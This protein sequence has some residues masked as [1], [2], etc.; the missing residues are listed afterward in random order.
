MPRGLGKEEGKASKVLIR[1]ANELIK[2]DESLEAAIENKKEREAMY[3]RTEKKL[4]DAMKTAGL[5]SFKAD[6]IGGFR[7]HIETYPN[8]KDKAA[9]VAF[10][11]KRKSLKFLWKVA[12]NGNTLKAWVKE[13]M[14]QGKKLPP[15]VDPYI[16]TQIR[17]Y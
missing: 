14:E 7:T 9:L 15:G 13:L 17:R 10:I 4:A 16:E 11:K 6:G 5:K 1:Y 12:I 8:T 3:R 2:A